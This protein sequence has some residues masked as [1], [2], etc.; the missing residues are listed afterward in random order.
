MGGARLWDVG[1]G[2]E[3]KM[4]NLSSYSLKWKPRYLIGLI[5]G[6]GHSLV[7]RNQKW[8]LDVPVNFILQGQI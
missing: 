3:G 1:G 8:V 2:R 7:L 5:N 4:M 6:L